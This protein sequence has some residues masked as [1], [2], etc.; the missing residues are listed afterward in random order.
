MLV[1]LRKVNLCGQRSALPFEN[2]ASVNLS[3][4]RIACCTLNLMEMPVI[5]N[6]LEVLIAFHKAYI[7]PHFHFLQLGNPGTGRSPGF[8]GRHSTIHYYLMRRDIDEIKGDQWLSN[9][10]FNGFCTTLFQLD[11]NKQIQQKRKPAVFVNRLIPSI[12]KYFRLFFLGLFSDQSLAISF[13]RY[14]LGNTTNSIRVDCNNYNKF[15]Q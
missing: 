9:D 1:P 12:K 6:N 3:C 14:I 13:A 8:R 5:M 15:H 2:S 7:F 10:N 11:Q 4:N